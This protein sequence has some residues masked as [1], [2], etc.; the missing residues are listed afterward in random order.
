MVDQFCRKCGAPVEAGAP[1]PSCG[2][3]GGG[4]GLDSVIPYNNAAA[5]IAYY[6]AVFGVIPC[7]GG[8]LLAPIAVILGFLG[9]RAAAKN[10]GAKGRVH[11]WIGI[12][13]G[14]LS[15]VGNVGAIIAIA[16]AN[17]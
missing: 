8:L 11:A 16:V 17:R 12:V 1:C 13:L 3:G 14:G 9:L 15:F 7:V 2:A 10:P 4:S 5:L 6:C